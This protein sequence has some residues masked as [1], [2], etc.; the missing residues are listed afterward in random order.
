MNTDLKTSEITIYDWNNQARQCKLS[1]PI[2]EIK[3][4]VVVV[5]SGDEVIEVRFKDSSTEFYDA[6]DDRAFGFRDGTYTVPEEDI[7]RWMQAADKVS[8]DLTISY[9]RMSRR[10]KNMA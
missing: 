8:S 10:W 9:H 1:K 7:E 2:S 3:E 4:I 5:L 6:S